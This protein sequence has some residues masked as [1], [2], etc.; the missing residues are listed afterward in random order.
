MLLSQNYRNQIL[1]SIHDITINIESDTSNN[2]RW[3]ENCYN[4]KVDMS[5]H[6]DNMINTSISIGWQIFYQSGFGLSIKNINTET[7]VKIEFVDPT[8]F[9]IP[10]VDS[11]TTVTKNEQ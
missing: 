5:R 7:P 6:D 2:I 1:K 10:V 4:D 3:H 9:N 8:K 11:T